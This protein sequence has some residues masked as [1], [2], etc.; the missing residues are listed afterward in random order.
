MRSKNTLNRILDQ[1]IFQ[2]LEGNALLFC[3]H[4][5]DAIKWVDFVVFK[6]ERIPRE[7]IFAFHKI[8]RASGCMSR[9]EDNLNGE[10]INMK[11]FPVL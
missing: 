10:V 8:A 6:A 11:H 9:S 5:D 3:V 4:I 7:E 2:F 1:E